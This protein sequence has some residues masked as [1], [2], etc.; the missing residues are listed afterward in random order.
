MTFLSLNT[1]KTFRDN[2]MVYLT[3]VGSD[4]ARSFAINNVAKV[5]NVGINAF[6]S[7]KKTSSGV[8]PDEH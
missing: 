6:Y 5:V 7:S 8:H 2:S 3:D 4:Q 1:V